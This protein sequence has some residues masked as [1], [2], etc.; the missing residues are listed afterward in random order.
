MVL[1]AARAENWGR[2]VSGAGTKVHV[3]LD[4]PE[5]DLTNLGRRVSSAMTSLPPYRAS[6]PSGNTYQFVRS[7]R[8]RWATVLA[9]VTAAPTL[10]GGLLLLLVRRSE[11]CTVSLSRGPSGAVVTVNGRILSSHLEALRS[12]LSEPRADY[13]PGQ[14]AE[15]VTRRRGD[16]APPTSLGHGM[17]DRHE[18]VPAAPA[19]AGPALP[20]WQG[21]IAR[22]SQLPPSGSEATERHPVMSPQATPFSLRPVLVFDSGL[23]VPLTSAVLVGRDPA[24]MV[25]GDAGAYLVRLDDAGLSV[26]KTHFAV[27]PDRDG[28]WIEDRHSTNGTTV[29]NGAGQRLSLTPGQRTLVASGALILFGDRQVEMGSA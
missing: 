5:S 14:G 27:G 15:A 7:N 1:L 9:C 22:I 16:A 12:A 17:P 26:S 2:S 21:M 19:A 13:S 28:A 23:R 10:G 4:V 11:V 29:L 25:P 8:P 6:P 18:A 20:A 24:P 3:S